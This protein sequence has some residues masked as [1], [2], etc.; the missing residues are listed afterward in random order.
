MFLIVNRGIGAAQRG[1]ET[2]AQAKARLDQP[3]CVILVIDEAQ[4]F[5]PAGL[6]ATGLVAGLNLGTGKMMRLQV[7]ERR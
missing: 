3:G 7:Y 5:T 6:A 4:D 2:A 1:C